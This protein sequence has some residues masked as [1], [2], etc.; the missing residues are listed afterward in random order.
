M[1]ESVTIYKVKLRIIYAHIY[2]RADNVHICAAQFKKVALQAERVKMRLFATL[3]TV[4]VIYMVSQ[5]SQI[6]IACISHTQSLRVL[7]FNK[8]IQSVYYCA[9]LV[10]TQF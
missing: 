2:A 3:L 4:F 5:D 8:V 1:K 10:A 6:I 7:M 9:K